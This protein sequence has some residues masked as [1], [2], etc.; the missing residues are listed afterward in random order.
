V[1][2][3]VSGDECVSLCLNFEPVLKE[4]DYRSKS[5]GRLKFH[6]ERLPKLSRCPVRSEA[7][8]E[9]CKATSSRQRIG[10]FCFRKERSAGSA[11]SPMASI[12]FLTKTK[13]Y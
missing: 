4:R 3:P 10:D 12:I 6:R 2:L 7:I 5:I 8:R 1:T 13:Y 11:L 9:K